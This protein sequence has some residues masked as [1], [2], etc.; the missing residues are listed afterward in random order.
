ME[1]LKNPSLRATMV[2][3]MHAMDAGYEN[4]CEIATP[5]NV[6][7]VGFRKE[8]NKKFEGKRLSEIA[9]ALGKDWAEVIIDLNV[10]EELQLGATQFALLELL[11]ERHLAERD[12][13]QAV[14]G[15]VRT[16]EIISQ[17]PWDTAHPEDNHVKQLVR[18]VRRAL[19]RVGIEDAIESR[20]GFGYRLLVETIRAK[21]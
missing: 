14:R 20:H 21:S 4:L 10:D 18:R 16:I 7:V 17:L 15:F 12:Q 19:E 8:A 5:E 3:E 1:N 2:A 6:M 11:A 9:A 13:P